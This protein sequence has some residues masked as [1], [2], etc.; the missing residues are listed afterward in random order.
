MKK[1]ARLLISLGVTGALAVANSPFVL[2]FQPCVKKE[3]YG[4]SATVSYTYSRWKGGNYVLPSPAPYVPA[5]WIDSESLGITLKNPQDVTTDVAGNLYITDSGNNRIVCTDSQFNVQR[6]ID[7]FSMNGSEQTFNNPNGCFVSAQG[8]MYIADTDNGRIVVLDSAGNLV[9]VIGRPVSDIL[10][11]S[12]KFNPQ[13][14]AVDSTGRIYVVAKGVYE[15]LM[16]FYENGVFS[17]FIGSNP[18]Q[19]SVFDVLWKSFLTQQ[20]KKKVEQYIPIEYT[21]L[22]LDD[23]SF[24]YCV[25][26]STKDNTPIRRLNMSGQDILIRDSLSGTPVSGD[27]PLDYSVS[28][29]GASQ[30]V[31]ICA[32]ENGLYYALDA[33]R[34][35]IFSYDSEGNLLYD[36]G[37]INTCQY[38]TF[39]KPA[40]IFMAGDNIGVLDRDLGAIVV[41]RPTDYVRAIQKGLNAY[42]LGDYQQSIQDWKEVLKIN[43][44]LEL[45]YSKIGMALYRQ[46]KYKESMSYF[47]KGLDKEHYSKAFNQYRKIYLRTHLGGFITGAVT[48]LLL[49]AVLYH[50]FRKRRKRG[51]SKS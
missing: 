9:R 23:S 18:V 33:K 6:V 4:E 47:E 22:F 50:L 30:F 12:F 31:D 37:G 24:I 27:V 13:K 36:F 5:Y 26:L 48:L 25:S 32:D 45:A 10:D 51:K 38:G 20:Q 40:A 7:R 39:L 34:G 29:T 14:L 2:G 41:F 43:G 3:I 28:I 35:R 46:E 19:A 49:S 1:I 42:K 8:W 11:K 16:V 21:N 17:G 15:G 44:N